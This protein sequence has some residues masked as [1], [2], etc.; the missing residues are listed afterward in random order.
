MK[1]K[2]LVL[3]VLST[4]LLLPCRAHPEG[5]RICFEQT[6][7]R[8]QYQGISS[9]CSSYSGAKHPKWSSPF[10]DDTGGSGIRGHTYQ[11]RIEAGEEIK[12]N[13]QYALCFRLKPGHSPKCQRKTTK[14]CT[15][16]SS[17][18]SW[19]TP[20]HDYTDGCRYSWLIESSSYSHPKKKFETCRVCFSARGSSQCQGIDSCSSWASVGGNPNPTWTRPFSDNI[21]KPRTGQGCTYSWY[22]D[23]T[24]I[25]NVVNCP[26][27]SPCTT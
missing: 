13:T 9:A 4:C 16:T 6:N 10:L 1:S 17:N 18:P 2:C 11:W 19:T 23:C 21:D 24:S 20:F 14:L 3:F 25:V 12:E 22:L 15:G 26:R 5:F 8:S 27:D 7:E